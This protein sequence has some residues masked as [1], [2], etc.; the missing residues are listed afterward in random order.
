[1]MDYTRF[2]MVARKTWGSEFSTHGGRD[3]VSL[4]MDTRWEYN[5]VYMA[6]LKTR[7]LGIITHRGTDVGSRR[8]IDNRIQDGLHGRAARRAKR[9]ETTGPTVTD[10]HTPH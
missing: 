5:T 7:G 4:W 3:V 2:Y 1:M 9:R 6:A 10:A 8:W